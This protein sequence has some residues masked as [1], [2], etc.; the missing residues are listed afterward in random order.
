MDP[1]THRQQVLFLWSEDSSLDGRVVAW[2]FHDGN[3]RSADMADQPYPTCADALSDG[4][5][6]IQASQLLPPM[7]GSEHTPSFLK[8]EFIFEKIVTVNCRRP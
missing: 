6:M 3:D 2:S 7:A 5:R 4:W 8:H 1:A